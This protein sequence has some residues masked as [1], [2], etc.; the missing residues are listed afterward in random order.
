MKKLMK[1]NISQANTEEKETR[2]NNPYSCK[3]SDSKN[4]SFDVFNEFNTALKKYVNCWK[5][6]GVFKNYNIKEIKIDIE[7]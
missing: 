1:S 5:E 2:N 7:R 3:F 6:M 4:S